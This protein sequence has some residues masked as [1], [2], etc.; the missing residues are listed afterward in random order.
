MWPSYSCLC[1]PTARRTVS[2]VQRLMQSI[3]SSTSTTKWHQRYDDHT[4]LHHQMTP[5]SCTTASPCCCT[6]HHTLRVGLSGSSKC[7]P[8]L[9][10]HPVTFFPRA[11]PYHSVQQLTTGGLPHVSLAGSSPSQR[12]SSSAFRKNSAWIRQAGSTLHCATTAAVPK[13]GRIGRL[14]RPLCSKIQASSLS[15]VL[16]SF[17]FELRMLK[18]IP[19]HFSSWT[20]GEGYSDI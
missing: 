17:L 1:L 18:M 3:Y 2:A 5:L 16:V 9:H 6:T 8:P 14:H 10:H 11:Q 12:S 7:F 13:L 15:I 19:L 4:I 20:I